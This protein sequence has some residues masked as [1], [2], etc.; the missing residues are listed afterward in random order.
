MSSTNVGMNRY[1]SIC[2]ILTLEQNM[3]ITITSWQPLVFYPKSQ[4]PVNFSWCLANF[5]YF[6]FETFITRR[7]NWALLHLLRSKRQDT[8]QNVFSFTFPIT[9]DLFLPQFLARICSRKSYLLLVCSDKRVLGS[10]QSG[11]S[12][13]YPAIIETPATYII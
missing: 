5:F 13:R 8:R 4:F 12:T 2:L 6:V 1:R 7:F 3:L 11:R 9:Q 10:L